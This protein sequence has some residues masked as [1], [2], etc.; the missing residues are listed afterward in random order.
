MAGCEI[1]KERCTLSG[2]S[3][4]TVSED[5]GKDVRLETA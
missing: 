5:I 1:E 3:D 2:V 4:H